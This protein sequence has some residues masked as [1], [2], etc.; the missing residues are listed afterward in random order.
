M[1]PPASLTA[2]TSWREYQVRIDIDGGEEGVMDKVGANLHI[3]YRGFYQVLRSNPRGL[4]WVSRYVP[5]WPRISIRIQHP[6]IA[7]S[8]TNQRP[9]FRSR[10]H[11]QPFSQSMHRDRRV[12]EMSKFTLTLRESEGCLKKHFDF[13]EIL[14]LRVGFYLCGVGGSEGS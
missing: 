12:T 2:L 14:M 6:I 9:L 10:D 8:L 13:A 5:D 1:T 7:Q 3:S 4:I 11:S